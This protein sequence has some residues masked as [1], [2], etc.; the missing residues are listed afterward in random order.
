VGPSVDFALLH[1]ALVDHDDWG[2]T[3]EIH[4]YRDLD[5]EFTDTCIKLEQLQVDLSAIQQ[6]HSTSESQLLL[7]RAQEQVE[8]LENVPR[9]PQAT[10]GVWKRKSGRGCPV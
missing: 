2:L 7:A 6:A 10:R 1:I 9:K 4:R 3:R 8:Q 5:R